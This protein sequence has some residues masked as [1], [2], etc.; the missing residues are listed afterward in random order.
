MDVELD[1]EMMATAADHPEFVLQHKNDPEMLRRGL[2][3]L[4]AMHAEI[5]DLVYYHGKSVKEA[6]RIV[7]VSE[8]T[9]K[10]R[11]LYARKKLRRRPSIS[12]RSNG[13]RWGGLVQRSAWLDRPTSTTCIELPTANNT[14]LLKAE[15]KY[16][17][18]CSQR[19]C[20]TPSAA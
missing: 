6:A 15:R 10:M 13:Q 12:R 9:V 5:I 4:P 2:M 7:D 8:A 19:Y 16:G 14:A 11:M 17:R 18:D 20:G 3:R 1:H